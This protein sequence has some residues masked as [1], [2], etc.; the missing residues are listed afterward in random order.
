[1]R[2]KDVGTKGCAL[3]PPPSSTPNL[4]Q[5]GTI[6]K[7]PQKG[8]STGVVKIKPP[9]PSGNALAPVLVPPKLTKVRR[10]DAGCAHRAARDRARGWR[11]RPV[12]LLLPS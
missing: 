8:G 2:P 9:L 6:G 4:Y 12:V 10:P 7:R 1:V 3:G 5:T 11:V